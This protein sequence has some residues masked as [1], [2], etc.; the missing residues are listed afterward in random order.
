MEGSL[1]LPPTDPAPSPLS[2]S[3][4]PVLGGRRHGSRD[5]SASFGSVTQFSR[6][7][8]ISE[9]VTSSRTADTQGEN[10]VSLSQDDEKEETSPCTARSNS[11]Q[12]GFA[13]SLK[14]LFEDFQ[15]YEHS[16]FPCECFE[17]NRLCRRCLT[18][19]S[20]H[21][22]ADNGSESHAVI[23]AGHSSKDGGVGPRAS[24]PGEGVEACD[25]RKQARKDTAGDADSTER[26]GRD[27]STWRANSSFPGKES[28]STT[29][30]AEPCEFGCW[31]KAFN[32]GEGPLRLPFLVNPRELREEKEQ[33]R[34]LEAGAFHVSKSFR[35][36]NDDSLLAGFPGEEEVTGCGENG[37]DEAASRICPFSHLEVQ[38]IEAFVRSLAYCADAY[39]QA[40]LR[41]KEEGEER[42]DAGQGHA[43]VGERERINAAQVEKDGDT[44]KDLNAWILEARHAATAAEE[45]VTLMSSIPSP[46]SSLCYSSVRTS[47][48]C[49]SHTNCLPPPPRSSSGLSQ[50]ESKSTLLSAGSSPVIGNGPADPRSCP[51]A[52][53]N[54]ESPELWLL[55]DLSSFL[56][57]RHRQ[58]I[59]KQRSRKT[60]SPL[61][62]ASI[63]RT[64]TAGSV[65]SLS[66]PARSSPCL[67]PSL[68]E[69]R[70]ELRGAMHAFVRQ[71]LPFLVSESASLPL[72]LAG[73]SR[74]GP[75]SLPCRVRQGDQ[76]K[77]R[78]ANPLDQ[79][80]EKDQLG[81][82]VVS[83]DGL[84]ELQLSGEI[85]GKT[86][87][88]AVDRSAARTRTCPTNILGQTAAVS[89]VAGKISS[90]CG[91]RFG[92]TP[93]NSSTLEAKEV[94]AK[95]TEELQDP[96]PEE[97]ETAHTKEPQK[98]KPRLTGEKE[99]RE[100]D[101]LVVDR[102]KGSQCRQQEKGETHGSWRSLSEQ[103]NREVQDTQL[104][105]VPSFPFVSFEACWA[106][107]S[108]A[109]LQRLPST[110]A[111]SLESEKHSDREVRT[112]EELLQKTVGGVRE[113]GMGKSRL[114]ER[115]Q[116]D[117]EAN[118]KEGCSSCETLSPNSV[119]GADANR[120]DG[121]DAL[122]TENEPWSWLREEA[123]RQPPVVGLRLTV[124]PACLRYF[125]PSPL[126]GGGEGIV[127]VDEPPKNETEA[128]EAER[129]SKRFRGGRPRT[130]R[131][132]PSTVETLCRPTRQAL[133]A[134][135][136]NACCIQDKAAGPP[137]LLS[138][139]ES[140]QRDEQDKLLFSCAHVQRR[141]LDLVFEPFLGSRKSRT[142]R[143][144]AAVSAMGKGRPSDREAEEIRWPAHQ[145]PYL[146]F[147]LLKINRDTSNALN[148]IGRG[149][150]RHAQ[151]SLAAA[152]TK[153]KRGITVQ[154][155]SVLRV[156]PSNLLADYYLENPRRDKNLHIAPL[157][158]FSYPLPLGGLKGNSFQ[159]VLRNLRPLSF[160]SASDKT[161]AAAFQ[162]FC[163]KGEA[164]PD[165]RSVP[166]APSASAG[167]LGVKDTPS[168]PSCPAWSSPCESPPRSL[169]S[170]TSLACTHD[171]AE[172][173]FIPIRLCDENVR[174]LAAQVEAGV[175]GMSS[176]GF[177]NYFGLQ[178]FGTHTVRTFEVGAALLRADWRE[179]VRLILG[180]QGQACCGDAGAAEKGLLPPLSSCA[181][182]S[183]SSHVEVEVGGTGQ[184][185]D[186]ITPEEKN[187]SQ[188]ASQNPGEEVRFL[189][190]CLP[191]GA[192][193]L[194]E[195]R[196]TS[197]IQGDDSSPL[198]G[199]ASKA[200]LAE[201]QQAGSGEKDESLWEVLCRTGDPQ[202]VL[203]MLA[204]HQ[205]IER[206]LLSS[207]WSAQRIRRKLAAKTRQRQKRGE[208]RELDS[209]AQE[210]V[211]VGHAAGNGADAIKDT[212]VQ[213]GTRQAP[214]SGPAGLEKGEE[215]S[216]EAV[217]FSTLDYFRALQ[218]LPKNTLQLY[219]HAAQSV[220]F[221]HVCSWRWRASQNRVQVGDLVR[222]PQSRKRG[223][224]S[225][226]LQCR[227]QDGSSTVVEGSSE[228]D[229][230]KKPGDL[231]SD[232]WMDDTA[233]D[234]DCDNTSLMDVQ[235]VE[236]PTEAESASIFDVVLPLPGSR[237]IYPPGLRDVYDKLSH[238]VLG[239]P[240][241]AFSR[242]SKS[243]SNGGLYCTVG[244]EGLPTQEE[245]DKN[246]VSQE[247]ARQ[248]KKEG[249]RGRNGSR[250]RGGF[251]GERSRGARVGS[252]SLGYS[253]LM[254]SAAA[255]SEGHCSSPRSSGD[256]AR[257]P[258]FLDLECKG[259][260]RPLLERARKCEWQLVRTSVDPD[261]PAVP[262]LHSDV[263]LLLM[264][265]KEVWF[266]RDRGK[267]QLA[268]SQ[269][270]CSD[271]TS[272]K[273]KTGDS[274][275]AATQSV[276]GEEPSSRVH[277]PRSSSDQQ[278]DWRVSWDDTLDSTV[279]RSLCAGSATLRDHR[280]PAGQLPETSD[281][282]VHRASTKTE[283]LA[284]AGCRSN[285]CLLLR[286]WLPP[287]TY[288][289]MALREL[290]KTNAPDDGEPTSLSVSRAQP[291]S[292]LEG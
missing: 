18:A 149:L 5:S 197:T 151:K 189:A 136:K 67:V 28:K 174:A 183:A 23:A 214:D 215:T 243:L 158:C 234:D 258:G 140:R 206:T 177:L 288:F 260:Y 203:R 97:N 75:C 262:L 238:E 45:L 160:P 17:R 285:F 218:E 256:G 35:L 63:P 198:N 106:Q 257:C 247:R 62:P 157:G 33:Q 201:R 37:T 16:H 59:V 155:C 232:N 116:A 69:L 273:E 142:Q 101:G 10:K 113:H 118:S 175:K 41:R 264:K 289:T 161:T 51:V 71:R 196:V 152:G 130:Q 199:S 229:G 27:P 12:E 284:I 137:V 43:R 251:G 221:N 73:F 245:P 185:Q 52:D 7:L 249:K 255:K 271:G 44:D 263:D 192:V 26:Q 112:K 272:S 53:W 39:N 173:Q 210:R 277:P 90:S 209:V 64:T 105:S 85:E 190:S 65:P 148:T 154:R 87:E 111:G 30:L 2:H 107:Q 147:V 58:A 281:S 208:E 94:P 20:P 124:K 134:M 8:G 38:N 13:A 193:L 250:G 202:A 82:E 102:E 159:V 99:C 24:E 29:S 240:L 181:D 156:S 278:A 236:S 165:A 283:S 78:Y 119:H 153:D 268:A 172:V 180:E 169:S 54:T 121:N 179:A 216:L 60:D 50:L 108:Q 204:R 145:G 230:A 79:E 3:R 205:H 261:A 275:H 237:V 239:V 129:E 228:E 168:R 144:E 227:G 188:T 72:D 187:Q 11:T 223:L 253:S 139:E 270:A 146:H 1:A 128:G 83:G 259:S 32:E 19:Q 171:G 194:G 48:P 150:R 96:L 57:E 219:L 66:R 109:L 191:P 98:K 47:A 195:A 170:P 235:I 86:G 25:P 244:E 286:L 217:C 233:D 110:G 70:K 182:Q 40:F 269:D 6:S 186:C 122:A 138:H 46:V 266:P 126:S 282:S 76:E 163:Q 212:H 100:E 287:G 162:F 279:V 84:G 132:S 292:S 252:D 92:F 222:K 231:L 267:L 291:S 123:A 104:L 4:C 164:S 61:T 81:T 91:L 88:A 290:M 274:G 226:S 89:W 280:V 103:S 131:N 21:S 176:R 49:S 207:L 36:S 55:G 68:T 135:I 166:P 248:H 220:L 141:V 93:R 133:V 276:N 242:V 254:S 184:V 143:S 22:S 120:A 77:S 246:H 117:G 9:F 265:E 114:G 127:T 213:N 34:L 167:Q 225:E 224:I 125:F 42:R 80:D 115:E 211:T 31:C 178:R 14:T 95:T 74:S 200:L 56:R 15:V 241:A